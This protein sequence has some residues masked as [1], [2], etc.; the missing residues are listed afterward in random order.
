MD[1]LSAGLRKV[2]FA[3]LGFL[4]RDAREKRLG[5]GIATI[6]GLEVAEGFLGTFKVAG[7]I[8]TA[9]LDGILGGFFLIRNEAR[10]DH[11]DGLH[12]RIEFN[13]INLGTQSFRFFGVGTCLGI[14]VEGFAGTVGVT[15]AEGKLSLFQEQAVLFRL[16]IGDHV[17][18]GR[19][20][21]Q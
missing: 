17:G 16:E 18:G 11:L 15:L 4:V 1:K 3:H 7:Q 14:R 8:L 10:I 19:V 13:R 2:E 5:L 6:D 20:R 9:A 12:R 21:R